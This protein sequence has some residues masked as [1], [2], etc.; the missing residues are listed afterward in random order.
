MAGRI[1]FAHCGTGDRSGRGGGENLLE[2]TLGAGFAGGNV[3]VLTC[4]AVD[5]RRTLFKLISDIGAVVD[6]SLAEGSGRQARE[7]R[8][9]AVEGHINGVLKEE[10]KRIDP[11]ALAL[12]T[13]RTGDDLQ[14]ISRELDKLVCYVGDRDRIDEGDVREVVSL[15]REQAIYEIMDAVGERDGSG[16][17]RLVSRLQ[18][19]SVHLL[20][21][22]SV[23]VRKVRQ[24]LWAKGF[25]TAHAGAQSA[26]GMSYGSFQKSLYKEI[27]DADR[28]VTGAMAPYPAFRLVQQAARFTLDELAAAME[29]LLEVDIRLKSGGLEPERLV[30]SVIVQLCAGEERSGL[31]ERVPLRPRS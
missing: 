26:S 15:S 24:L 3:L 20:A 8:K 19:Q 13:A 7:D 12:L 18:E 11:R 21:I 29:R 30:E 16:A 5:R 23:V 27:T 14:T 1:G 2:Q 28:T 10:G 6:L 9:G 25:T 22:H 31:R 17:L 4:L